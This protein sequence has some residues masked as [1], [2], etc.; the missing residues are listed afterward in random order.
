MNIIS[1]APE[2]KIV[3]LGDCGV[4]KTNIWTR[5]SKNE[6]S[7]E[8]KPSKDI[9]IVTC[10]TQI[11]DTLLKV[12]IWDTTGDKRFSSI[13]K[14]Y[15]KASKVAVIVC[16]VTNKESYKNIEK[17]LTYVQNYG[18][19]QTRTIVVGNK[20]DLSNLREVEYSEALAIVESKGLPYLEVSALNSFNIEF[21]YHCVLAEIYMKHKQGL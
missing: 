9:Q 13:K 10:N 4:G 18:D 8:S 6:F 2:T 14:N 12:K 21:M 11:E 16:D 19:K 5:V 20:A 3:F 17:W 7:L 1:Q 15:M